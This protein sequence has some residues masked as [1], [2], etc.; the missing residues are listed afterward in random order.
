MGASIAAFIIARAGRVKIVLFCAHIR[1]A[2]LAM[3]R[4]LTNAAFDSLVF[5]VG[6]RATRAGLLTTGAGFHNFS[7]LGAAIIL[8]STEIQKFTI[9]I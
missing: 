3:N 8:H 2:V 9:A 6:V 1:V 4:V 7:A 5:E